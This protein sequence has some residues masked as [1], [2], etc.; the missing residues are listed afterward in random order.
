[1]GGLVLPDVSPCTNISCG[2]ESNPKEAFG[3]LIYLWQVEEVDKCAARSHSFRSRLPTCWREPMRLQSANLHACFRT[4]KQ[5]E[6]I[7][8]NKNSCRVPWKRQWPRLQR[9]FHH[10]RIRRGRERRE[11][12]AYQEEPPSS[13]WKGFQWRHTRWVGGSFGERAN[14]ML[15]WISSLRRLWEKFRF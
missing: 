9:R 12:D 11:K 1:M 15:D 13:L 7:I 10:K 8:R 5:E 6:G 2:G 4:L 14:A 3:S